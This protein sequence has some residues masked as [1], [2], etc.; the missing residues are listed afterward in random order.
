VR[1]SAGFVRTAMKALFANK[2]KRLAIGTSWALEFAKLSKSST[3]AVTPSHLVSAVS[4]QTLFVCFLS[5]CYTHNNDHTRTR[6]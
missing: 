4:L 3:D 2:A 1:P 5:K 6:S